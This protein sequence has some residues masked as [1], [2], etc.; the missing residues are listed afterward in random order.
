MNEGSLCVLDQSNK[1][2]AIPRA[3]FTL[4]LLRT[5]SMH[6]EARF[7]RA[8]VNATTVLGRDV[9]TASTRRPRIAEDRCTSPAKASADWTITI[10]PPRATMSATTVFP[11]ARSVADRLL[12]CASVGEGAFVVAERSGA[13]IASGVGAWSE[14]T[15]GLF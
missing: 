15:A 7:V 13:D 3:T 11:T 6:T 1:G 12:G 14:R 10:T 8:R 9:A 5:S 4:L 2:N